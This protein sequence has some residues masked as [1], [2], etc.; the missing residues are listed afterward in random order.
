MIKIQAK[1]SCIIPVYNEEANIS[2]VL[3]ILLKIAWLDEVIVVDDGSSDKT[4][5]VVSRFKNPK[6]HLVVC[7]RNQGKGAA[8]YR[9]IKKAQN[10]LLIFIDGDLI[11]LKEEH[12]LEIVNPI[13]FSKT[14]DLSLG[15]FAIS[16]LNKNAGTK[17]ANRAV[18]WITGQ[19]AIYR[20]N[21]PDLSAIKRSRY[22]VD[23]LISKKFKKSQIKI[24]KLD[25]LSQS[26]K[27]DKLDFF[28]AMRARA[29][30]YYQISKIL[31]SS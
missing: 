9:G 14:A 8:L 23:L 6:L 1:I 24:V 17:I 2:N 28:S 21:L 26:V 30:M 25:G 19:R 13:L 11:G 15:V 31:R 20:K 12:L 22:G 27:E 5:S 10:D 16:K 4:V 18:P 7:K 29:K 3:E